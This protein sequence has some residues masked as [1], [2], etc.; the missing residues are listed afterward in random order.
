[1]ISSFDIDG[2]IFLQDSLPGLTPSKQ[3]IIITGRSKDEIAETSKMLLC[4]GIRNPVFYNP[5]P[6]E[7]K[8]RETSGQFKADTINRLREE[9]YPI[10]IHFDD[11]PVQ[12][13][14]IKAST[15]IHVIEIRHE[16]TEKENVRHL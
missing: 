8:T 5:L 1:M 10:A 15:P 11:D 14:I 6:F 4:R 16:L 2:V 13:E 12:I 7:A 9:G 3:D